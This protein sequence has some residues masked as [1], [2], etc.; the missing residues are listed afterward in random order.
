MEQNQ[1]LEFVKALGHA[2]RLRVVGVLTKS[3]A[4]IK[5]VAEALNIPFRDA[6]NHLAYLEHIGAVRAQP[7][8]NRQ[9]AIYELAEDSLENLARKQ[10]EGQ[11]EGL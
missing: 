7:A 11:K 10:F 4:S 2:D 9:D 3:P 8:E 5:Q 1:M 6:M